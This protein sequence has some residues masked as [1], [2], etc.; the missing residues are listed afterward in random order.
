MG[1]V[2]HRPLHHLGGSA[3]NA[4]EQVGNKAGWSKPDEPT[5]YPTLLT[6]NTSS[7]NLGGSQT[8]WSEIGKAT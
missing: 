8:I 1:V 6:L 2:P 4:D 3:G 5:P 7:T